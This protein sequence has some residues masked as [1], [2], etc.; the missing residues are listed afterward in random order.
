MPYRNWHGQTGLQRRQ[1]GR[2]AGCDTSHECQ[3]A[4]PAGNA[5]VKSPVAVVDQIVA[6]ELRKNRIGLKHWAGAYCMPTLR[7][8]MIRATAYSEP[9]CLPPAWNQPKWL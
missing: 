4:S 7:K 1:A 6:W 2:R 3:P 5:T 8:L 9:F